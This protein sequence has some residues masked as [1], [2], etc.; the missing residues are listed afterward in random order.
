MQYALLVQAMHN[1]TKNRDYFA[2]VDRVDHLI[3]HLDESEH[4]LAV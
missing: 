4:V 2:D 1:N 3:A